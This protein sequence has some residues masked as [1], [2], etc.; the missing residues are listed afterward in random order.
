ML[1]RNPRLLW[2]IPTATYAV[3]YVYLAMFHQRWWLWDTVVHEGGTLTLWETTLYASHFLGHIPSLVIIAVLLA[4]WFR[5]LAGAPLATGVNRRWLSAAFV[6]VGICFAGSVWHFGWNETIDYLFWRKQSVVR[7]ETGGSFLL[8]LPSTLS[9]V[10]LIPLYVAVL[11][12]VCGRAVQW[13]S[14]P[15]LV[16]LGALMTSVV[17]AG[18][19][20]GSFSD[21]RHALT[22]P[23]Y[24]AHSVRELATFPLTFFPL[25]IALWIAGQERRTGWSPSARVPLILLAL[26]AVPLLAYQVWLPLAVGVGELA[27]QPGFSSGPLPIPYLLAAHYFEH[28]L[29]TIFYIIICNAILSGRGMKR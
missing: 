29:D 24:L 6:F 17:F 20:S 13:R 3:S 5:V 12:R 4:G 28:L 10:I 15:L 26:V 18:L 1:A 23:R 2:W 8:H 25:P 7:N 16:V 14:R 22:D 19:V 27:Q 21:I 11:L 9:L